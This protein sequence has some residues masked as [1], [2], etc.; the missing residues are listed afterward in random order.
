M[1]QVKLLKINQ[2]NI[3]VLNEVTKITEE[4]YI[5]NDSYTFL[6][7]SLEVYR[8]KEYEKDELVKEIIKVML[9]VDEEE[10][11]E[12][13]NK[14][15]TIEEIKYKAWFAPV[16]GMKLEEEG[17]KC[18]VIFIRE[19][20]ID[21]KEYFEDII[22]LGKFK[23]LIGKKL[24]V[25]KEILSRISLATSTLIT[26][27]E[28]PN[29]IILPNFSLEGFKRTYKAVVPKNSTYR[30]R[31][32]QEVEGIDFDLVDYEF[33]TDKVDEDGKRVN[34]INIFDGGAI[35]TPQIFDTIGETLNRND[36]D[37]AIIRAYGIGIK[38][39]VTKF[40]ILGY[41]EIMHSKIGDTD[42]CYK[43]DDK[44]Y[45]IDMYGKGREV[46][47]NT[48]LLNESM[49][50]LANK[51]SSMDEYYE[52]L[53]TKLNNETHMDTY[54]LLT[55]LYITKVN[56]SKSELGEYRRLNYQLFNALALTE[57]EYLQLAEQ[58][59]LLF[60]K[61]LKP[62]DYDADSKEFVANTDIINIFYKQ[63]CKSEEIEGLKEIN[64]IVDKCNVLVQLNKD[65]VKL[66]EVKSQLSSLIEK[67]VRD[68]AQGRITVKATYNYI[69]IDPISYMNLAI[70]RKQG[71]NGLNAGEFYC[72]NINDGETR[73]IFRNPCMAYSEIH[74]IKFVRNAFLDNWLCKSSEIVYFNQKSDIHAL[75]GS[76][77]ADGDA[78]TMIDNKIIRNAVIE[79]QDGKYFCFTADGK[80]V[81]LIY[82]DNGRFEATYKPSGNLIGNVATIAVSVNNDS[83]NLKDYYRTDKDRLYSW[84][85]IKNILIKLN[86]YEINEEKDLTKK[87]DI[88]NNAIK[89]LIEKGKIQYTS[90]ADS[91]AI[92]KKIKQQF[93]SR[94]KDIYSLLYCSSLVIDSP[95]TMNIINVN[96]Y[97]RAVREKYEIKYTSKKT[98]K[99]SWVFKKVN[100]LQYAKK[101]N[102]IN[103]FSLAY[104]TK[105]LLDN[106]SKNVQ[107][108]LLDIIEERRKRNKSFG[109]NVKLLQKQLENNNYNQEVVDKCTEILIAMYQEYTEEND[110]ISDKYR[111]KSDFISKKARSKEFNKLTLNYT[112]FAKKLFKKADIYSIAYA[113]SQL[114][115]CS[116][117][118]IINF[119]MECLIKVDELKPSLKSNYVEDENGDIE[120]MHKKY[121]KYE[122]LVHY[123][124]SAIKKLNTKDLA[125][126]GVIKE[127]RFITDKV[128]EIT[129]KIEKG[130]EKDGYYD[131][132]INEDLK[133]A[134]DKYI[135][136]IGDRTTIRINGFMLKQDGTKSIAKKSFG[137]YFNV[138]IEDL[139]EAV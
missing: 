73:T 82:D 27:I 95:K 7:K 35:A 63:C 128:E 16:G 39:L 132:E 114:E 22:S 30:N 99:V 61:L 3:N 91:E 129:Q 51:F 93:Y 66:R 113:L 110:K 21:F 123:S 133:V 88:T 85:D 104:Q 55:K 29:F 14:G 100:F 64:N 1:R 139:I 41:L 127:V 126:I 57:N 90:N 122:K 83:Q 24:Y 31:E 94:E 62:F 48:L 124:E 97:T 89:D 15:I 5:K 135:K 109:Q 11:R 74:N 42:Y 9:P 40:D 118:F 53:N 75:I 96:E 52:I 84:N 17:S 102:E 49:V 115:S 26:E 65:N 43:K 137:V 33:D 34:E 86:K 87:W 10:A 68:I 78:T 4:N 18:E 103:E 23:E 111:Y 101:K 121:K 117:R 46:T 25:N 13:W 72:R 130:I 70:T 134:D 38:G 47:D 59:I 32:D 108:C 136:N 2:T 6:I 125:R 69:G 138:E 67:R 119:F 54:N 106:F 79:P 8:K 80:K 44:F 92:R 116:E 77:D 50:K 28:M 105:S 56:K 98:G 60:K 81:P 20:F 107:K 37:F 12:Q 19:D 112:E 58:D 71:N 36:I 120:Y 76:S 45:L 131:L